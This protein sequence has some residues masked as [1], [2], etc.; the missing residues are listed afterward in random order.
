MSPIHADQHWLQVATRM[1]E[2]LCALPAV[3]N[4][5][6]CDR[7]ARCLVP[8][9]DRCIVAV[10]LGTLDPTGTITDRE[11]VG[12]SA[13]GPADHGS[14]GHIPN[15]VRSRADR[16]PS[17]GFALSGES[18]ERGFCGTADRFTLPR[19]WRSGPLGRMWTD[20]A[21]GELTIAGAPVGAKTPGR[22]IIVM[23][24]RADAAPAQGAREA[25][26]NVV[27]PLLA[28]R[29]VLA[30]G[31]EKTQSGDWLTSREQIVLERLTLGMSV[32]D[33]A[34]EMERSAHTVHDHVKSLHKKLRASSRGE[35]IARA[36]GHIT[37]E[38]K[39]KAAKPRPKA[40][41]VESRVQEV[42]P[43]ARRPVER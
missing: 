38:V 9:V 12:A 15:L 33:I 14:E 21:T 30:I 18:L 40:E 13:D 25:V 3:A 41:P 22:T 1:T 17:L 24:A 27:M 6:W 11:A 35:L 2:R 43:T 42:K 4:P 36:L 8:L 29:A 26:L 28:R 10:V 7:A 19:D 37:T 5:D 31:P 20:V 32:S 34:A 16:L 23:I 39:P